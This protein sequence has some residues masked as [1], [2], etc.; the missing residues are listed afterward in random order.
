M[1]AALCVEYGMEEDGLSTVA[2][3][4][5]GYAARRENDFGG[6]FEGER[7]YDP[8]DNREFI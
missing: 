5:P 2:Q 4:K 3:L 7:V 8:R 1:D 6:K